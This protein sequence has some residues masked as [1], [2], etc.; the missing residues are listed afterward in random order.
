M[1]AGVVGLAGPYVESECRTKNEATTSSVETQM[2]RADIEG[3]LAHYR[4]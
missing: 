3:A 1:T 4:V 2:L